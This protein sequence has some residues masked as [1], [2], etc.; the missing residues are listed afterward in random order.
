MFKRQL[1]LFYGVCKMFSSSVLRALLLLHRL[2]VEYWTK[3]DELLKVRSPMRV[4]AIYNVSGS[5]KTRLNL[6]ALTRQIGILFVAKSDGNFTS[7]DFDTAMEHMQK[8]LPNLDNLP[9][10]AQRKDEAENNQTSVERHLHALLLSRLLV[11]EYMLQLAP[12]GVLNPKDW[13]YLQLFPRHFSGTD[14]FRELWRTLRSVDL[15]DLE[16]WLVEIWRKIRRIVMQPELPVF[17]D[18]AQACLNSM[19]D[20]F[21]SPS[22]P[23]ITR[24]FLSALTHVFAKHIPFTRLFLSGTGLSL[25]HAHNILS[26]FTFKE[27]AK[28]DVYVD[29]GA[30]DTAEKFM[31]FWDRYLPTLDQQPCFQWLRGR[32][33]M[34]S[35]Y[36]ER[37]YQ[38]PEPQAI[39]EEMIDEV[40]TSKA[41]KKDSIYSAL[42]QIAEGKRHAFPQGENVMEIIQRIVAHFVFTGEGAPLVDEDEFRL[43]DVGFARLRRSVK[44]KEAIVDEPLAILAGLKWIEEQTPGGL[45]KFM[46]RRMTDVAVSAGAQGTVWELCCAYAFDKHFDGRTRFRDLSLVSNMKKFPPWGDEPVR[47]GRCYRENDIIKIADDQMPSSAPLCSR[48]PSHTKGGFQQWLKNP[49]HVK[50][51]LPDVYAGPDIAFILVTASGKLIPAFVQVKFRVKIDKADTVKTSVPESF[52]TNKAGNNDLTELTPIWQSLA[53]DYQ[54]AENG[55]VRFIVTFPADAKI[56]PGYREP[57]STRSSTPPETVVPVTAANVGALFPEGHAAKVFVIPTHSKHQCLEAAHDEEVDSDRK[58]GK[59]RYEIAQDVWFAW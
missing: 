29:L 39:L 33:R 42:Q 53:S 57:P 8:H 31:S 13:M 27:T 14:F 59:V 47:V 34:L 36:I 9:V 52:Y 45:L 50:F 43:I 3:A 12:H 17:V 41:H 40:T 51:Y 4:T 23:N 58:K 2:G 19:L 48:S 16:N 35:T 5:G 55:I 21:L 25:T 49:N 24:P 44:L 6:E 28:L 38:R 46:E 15:D 56:V 26:S 18:E 32:H 30:F 10:G 11:L 20:R 54:R 22:D 1:M 37:V 7:D